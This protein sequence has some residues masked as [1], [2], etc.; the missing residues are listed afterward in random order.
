MRGA[1]P[2]GERCWFVQKGSRV[3]GAYT[4]EEVARFLLLGRIRN[5]DRVSCDGERWEPV[6]AIPEL[7]P[8]ELL[9]LR[10]DQ[11]QRWEVYSDGIRPVVNQ[12][13]EVA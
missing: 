10:E 11:N 12:E 3:L 5:T 2:E 7:I 4:A 13:G 8:D 6:I 1:A 9:D